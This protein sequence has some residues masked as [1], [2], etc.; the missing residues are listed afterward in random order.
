MAPSRALFATPGGGAVDALSLVALDNHEAVAAALAGSVQRWLD[1]EWMP[2]DCH[3]A[4]GEACGAT[5]VRCRIAEGET[6]LAAVMLAVADALAGDWT[7]A[8][9]DAFVNAWDVAN[10]VSDYLTKELGVEGCEC[11][12]RIY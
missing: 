4:I 6:D 2:Q 5:Y 8:Y 9:D 12:A 10:Y 1:A 7:E 3:R 11:S